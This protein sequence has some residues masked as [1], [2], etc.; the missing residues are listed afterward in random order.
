M[1]T[2]ASVWTHAQFL[3]GA[4]IK[5]HAL[6]LRI[7]AGNVPNFVDLADRRLGRRHPGPAQ[8]R[9][10]AHDGQLRDAGRRACRL[11]HA[12]DADACDKLFAAA[13]PPKGNAPTDTL[14]AAQSIARYPWYQPERLFAL[15]GPVLSDPAG[16]E[17]CG[18]FRSCR[19]STRAQRLGAAAQ[20][21]R[22][23]LSCGRQGHVRQRGQPLGRRQLHRRL[24][25]AGQRCGR[26]TPPSS[27]R[28]AARFRRSPPASPAAEWK[29]APSARPS[30]PRTMPGSPATAASPSR[31]STR[32]ASR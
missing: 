17:P 5:G 30:T 10:D 2:V 32:T 12:G 1:T 9:P 29:E 20:V 28:T 24:A 18:R 6:G 19:T 21:R 22:R 8:Q 15:L 13:T 26:A 14:T 25:G 4:A 3:D 23:R 7:A 16:Q 11:R 31:C 27:R